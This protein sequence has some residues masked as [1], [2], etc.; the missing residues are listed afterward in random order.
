M[1]GLRGVGKT[2][3]LGEISRE[4]RR[5]G[6]SVIK[7]EAREGVQLRHELAEAA[8]S[9]LEDLEPTPAL[10]RLRGWL[11][12]FRGSFDA[13][14][15]LQV[16]VDVARAP[17]TAARLESDTVRLFRDLGAAAREQDR[18]VL[19]IIDELQQMDKPGM[20][21]LC[22]AIHESDQ[23]NTPIGLVAAGLPNLPGR[24]ADAKSY[25]E[26]QFEY[27]RIDRLDREAAREALTAPLAT[28]PTPTSIEPA[29][30]EQMLDFANGYPMA[31]QTVGSAAWRT[32]PGPQITDQDMPRALESARE[33]LA[34]GLYGAR[35]DRAT[36]RQRDYLAGIAHH[37]EDAASGDVARALGTDSPGVARV[38]EGLIENG[39]IY[40]SGYGRVAF[41][42][43]GFGQYITDDVQHEIA[44]GPEA[45]PDVTPQLPPPGVDI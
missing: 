1:S 40:Q 39:L 14:G 33:R 2:V 42:I 30:V 24:L 7:L 9:I 3:L 26:R 27:P 38:R 36:E 15:Q 28:T 16:G 37:G 43:P 34:A 29:A 44:P 10:T 19:L 45:S 13:D 23:E 21:A 32:A 41:T 35:W 20:E 5:E 18:G 22:A 6:W 11:P 17:A 31:L 25:A 12:T 4:A 8:Q